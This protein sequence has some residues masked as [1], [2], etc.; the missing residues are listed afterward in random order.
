MRTEL[1]I[2]REYERS[3]RAVRSKLKA[4]F[5]FLQGVLQSL[6]W[7]LEDNAMAP[8]RCVLPCPRRK[9]LRKLKPKAKS[10]KPK[11]GVS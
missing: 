2:K 6:A 5:S 1:A 4:N 8:V 3:K 7:V 9:N 10:Q 11:A